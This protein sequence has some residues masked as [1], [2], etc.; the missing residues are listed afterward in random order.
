MALVFL[1]GF[2]KMQ[3]QTTPQKSKNAQIK[4]N[5]LKARAAMPAKKMVRTAGK[6]E[7]DANY[8]GLPGVTEDDD[9]QGRT[10][11]FLSVMVVNKLPLD[12]PK[13]EKGTGVRYYNNVIDNYFRQHLDLLKEQSKQKLSVH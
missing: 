1:V 10:Q 2:A 3:A 12:F 8:A 5:A 6:G 4:E 9:Y 7:Q 13:Y 11:E